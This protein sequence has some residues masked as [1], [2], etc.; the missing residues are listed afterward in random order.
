MLGQLPQQLELVR[1]TNR[2]YEAM[3]ADLL[4]PV[5]G[6]R[7]FRISADADL[8]FSKTKESQIKYGDAHVLSQDETSHTRPNDMPA[9]G[10][11]GALSNRPPETPTT[12]VNPPA[13]G[14]PPNPPQ[15][16]PPGAGR[17]ARRCPRCG[18][19]CRAGEG[20][21]EAK[22]APPVATD[23][24]KTTNYD[25]DHTVQYS[26]RPAW[27]LRA[28]NIAVLVNN[29]ASNPIP[30][31]RIQAIDKLV[32]AAVGSAQ[33]PR[34]TVV[35]MPFDSAADSTP[36]APGQW[37]RLP[38]MAAVR[39]NA[40]LALGGLL[41]LWGG[42]LPM[43]RRV[44]QMQAALPVPRPRSAIAAANVNVTLASESPRAGWSLGGR[45]PAARTATPQDFSRIEPETV[46]MLAANDPARTAQVIKGWITSDRGS[47]NHD[48]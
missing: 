34:V 30:A 39:D 11:P 19:G 8:D 22:A 25:I 20:P 37:W 33:T 17:R 40:V 12:Q 3:I 46:R 45:R 6:S 32:A 48:A 10:I 2:R 41:V 4:T 5:L 18:A 47:A 27:T 16:P 24:H 15:T 38:A 7:N 9:I 13:A 44:E 31:E 35:D 42:I 26:E 28:I 23:N 29:P 36:G 43:L 14:Q 1:A 21:A